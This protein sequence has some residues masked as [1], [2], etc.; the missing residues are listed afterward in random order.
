MSAPGRERGEAPFDAPPQGS[1][2]LK[3]VL[4]QGAWAAVQGRDS[5][6]IGRSSLRNEKPKAP[7]C[8]FYILARGLSE[9]SIT[10]IWRRHRVSLQALFYGPSH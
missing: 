1:A 7:S 3:P 4:V 6:V 9:T 5:Y 2:V 8:A 10:V